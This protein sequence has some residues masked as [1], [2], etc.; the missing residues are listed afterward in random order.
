MYYE[1][2][3]YVNGTE[4]RAF[5]QKLLMDSLHISKIIHCHKYAEIHIICGGMAK[6]RIGDDILFF[7]DGDMCIIPPDLYHCCIESDATT[8]HIA[9]QTDALVCDFMCGTLPDTIASELINVI[10]NTD[11]L[12][13]CGKLSSLLSFACS[14]FFKAAVPKE[15]TDRAAIIYEFISQNYNRNIKI[16]DLAEL[17]HFSDKQ[18]ERLVKKHT[19]VTFKSALADYRITVADYLKKHTAMS[20]NEIADY[21]GY[22]S[23]SGFWKAKKKRNL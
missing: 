6:Y 10:E 8:K 4:S 22:S 23:Y 20:D 17:L 13:N 21:I 3:L 5:I 9:F 14:P 18:T 12:Q 7:S 19:G 11:I 16:S 2:N 1:L 15:M